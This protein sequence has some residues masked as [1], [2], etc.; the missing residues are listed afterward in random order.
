MNFIQAAYSPKLGTHTNLLFHLIISQT[1]LCFRIDEGQGNLYRVARGCKL[2]LMF[3]NYYY[4]YKHYVCLFSPKQYNITSLDLK[5]TKLI[6]YN[7]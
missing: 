4:Y 5:M 6:T 3:Y 1:S 7:R 2:N